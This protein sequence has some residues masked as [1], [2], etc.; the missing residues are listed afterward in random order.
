MMSRSPLCAR[1]GFA[2]RQ[3]RF[4]RVCAKPLARTIPVVTMREMYQSGELQTM[5]GSAKA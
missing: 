3:N 1:D 5:L 2:G 4:R